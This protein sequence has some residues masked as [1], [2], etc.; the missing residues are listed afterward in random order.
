MATKKRSIS[1]VISRSKVINAT[2]EGQTHVVPPE[3]PGYNAALD[4]LKND[5]VDEFRTAL[6]HNEI[7]LNKVA[8]IVKCPLKIVN[9][10]VINTV[11]NQPLHNYLTKKIVQFQREGQDFQPLLKFLGNVQ[12]NPSFSV[13]NNLYDFLSHGN[14]PITNDGCFL[15]YKRVNEDYKDHYSQTFDHSIGA[16][17]EMPRN[18]VDDNN[19]QLCSVGFHVGTINYVNNFKNGPRVLVKVDPADVVAVDAREEKLRT[20]SYKV[21]A[22]YTHDL[23]ISVYLVDETK[24]ERQRVK[25]KTTHH[26]EKAKKTIKTIKKN[27]KKTK[28]KAKK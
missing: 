21:I 1:F 23:D 19:R 11:T 24:P 14:L 13:V 12:N 6:E 16:T 17:I 26:K 3:H 18:L 28:P 15:G 7:V 20:C 25:A 27:L 8:E 4:A 22:H 10:T 2:I 5:N 9:G